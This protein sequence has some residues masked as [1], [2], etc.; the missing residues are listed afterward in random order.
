MLSNRRTEEDN[1]KELEEMMQEAMSQILLYQ[2]EWTN[3]NVSDPGIAVLEN[4]TAFQA[5]QRSSLYQVSDQAMEM[6]CSLAGFYRKKGRAARVWLAG[7]GKEGPDRLLPGQKLYAGG[8]CFETEQ[9]ED[10]KGSALTGVFLETGGKLQDMGMRLQEETPGSVLLFGSRPQTGDCLYFMMERLPCPGEWLT[11]WVKAEPAFLRNRIPETECGL[12]ADL[13]WSLYT[14]SGYCSIVHRDGSGA[15]L[16]DGLIRLKMPEME[17]SADPRLG[18]RGYTLRC[19]L[20]RAEYDTLPRVRFFTD[21]LFP[22]RQR[23]T[24]AVTLGFHR[25]EGFLAGNAMLET[26]D[27]TVYGLEQDGFYYRYQEAGKIVMTEKTGLENNKNRWFWREREGE[28]EWRFTLSGDGLIRES[29]EGKPCVMLV[30]RQPERLP[31]DRIGRIYGYVGETLSLHPLCHILRDDFLLSACLEIPDG[32]EKYQFYEPETKERG[33]LKY[34]LLE[35]EGAIRIED[36]GVYEEAVLSLCTCAVHRG[37]AGNIRAGNGFSLSPAEEK[38]AF[39]NP[40]TGSG[41]REEEKTEAMGRR[42]A[43]DIRRSTRLVT[44]EDYEAVIRQIPGLGIHKV[45]AFAPEGG[46]GGIRVAVKPL[47]EEP[48]PRLPA[49]Y[50][51]AIQAEIEKRRMLAA[52][53]ILLDP[54][55]VPVDVSGTVL[56]KPFYDNAETQVEGALIALLDCVSTERPFGS[57]LSFHEICRALEALDCVAEVSRLVLRPRIQDNVQIRGGDIRMQESSLCHPGRLEL[58]YGRKR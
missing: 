51:R 19:R 9:E 22:V 33:G 40:F 3:Y 56:I 12:F 50:R 41:G 28:G 21:F 8:L 58:E 55:Y 36:A 14:E 43:A 17:G 34:T 38:P 1:A 49:V 46:S 57:V 32:G 24:L 4:L 52:R 7:C 2:S 53:V 23:D 13:S 54:V 48:Y 44:Q 45:R 42:F 11:I 39:Y 30:L 47:S 31:G 26:G 5:L 18:G 25:A 16:Q 15:F 35:E 20:E 37:D 6:L 27:L 29:R 10:T